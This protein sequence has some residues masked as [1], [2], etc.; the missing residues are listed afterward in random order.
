MPVVSENISP[1]DLLLQQGLTPRLNHYI[2][3]FDLVRNNENT[4]IL[5]QAHTLNSS[6]ACTLRTLKVQEMPSSRVNRVHDFVN[7]FYSTLL[8]KCLHRPSWRRDPARS[9][10]RAS[11]PALVCWE[12]A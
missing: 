7:G 12:T 5:R 9:Y 2:L 6:G 1:C 10:T 11:K 3:V 8:I 4:L